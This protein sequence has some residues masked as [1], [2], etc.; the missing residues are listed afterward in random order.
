M[1]NFSTQWICAECGLKNL[2]TEWKELCE[3][4]NNSFFS[5]RVKWSN[6]SNNNS[7]SGNNSNTWFPLKKSRREF[8]LP[9]TNFRPKIQFHFF[10]ILA[11]GSE[12]KW[13]TMFFSAKK[14]NRKKRTWLLDEQQKCENER[15]H[16]NF[17]FLKVCRNFCTKGFVVVSS[18]EFWKFRIGFWKF[19]A[20]FEIDE[21]ERNIWQLWVGK[22][23]YKKEA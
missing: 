22:S 7:S 16:K 14:V 23:E 12:K 5:S 3:K 6:N 1:R 10:F 21:T 9:K 4:R 19:F 18:I 20:D 15:R 11:E 2:A 8:F 17:S 13:L